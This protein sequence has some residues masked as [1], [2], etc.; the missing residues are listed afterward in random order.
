MIYKPLL[1]SF[2]KAPS[3]E[4]R[5]FLQFPIKIEYNSAL[6]LRIKKQNQ[7]FETSK[8]YQ[9]LVMYYYYV[10]ELPAYRPQ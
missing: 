2:V 9:P 7:V 10:T 6:K 5:Q 3:Y 4:K 1:R 8:A